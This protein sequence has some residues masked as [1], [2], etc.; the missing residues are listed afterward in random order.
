[1]LLNVLKNHA[2]SVSILQITAGEGDADPHTSQGP[3]RVKKIRKIL[4]AKGIQLNDLGKHFF[5][6]PDCGKLLSHRI[7]TITTGGYCYCTYFTYKETGT[8]TCPREG[9]S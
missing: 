5:S 9:A 3:G 2:L 7:L 4:K 1:M 6:V 8:E